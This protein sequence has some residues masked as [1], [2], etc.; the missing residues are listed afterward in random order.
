MS[1]NEYAF[2][3][4]LKY[5]W[6]RVICPER[7]ELDRLKEKYRKYFYRPKTIKN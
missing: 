7:E 5:N 3:A 6:G 2:T 1:M 4:Q